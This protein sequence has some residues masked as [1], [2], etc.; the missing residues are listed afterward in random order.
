MMKK[1]FAMAAAAALTAGVTVL[2]SNPFSDVSASHWS[3]QAV[4][5]LSAQGI[6][7]GYPDG[8]FKGEKNITRYEMAQIIARLMAKEDQYNVEQR[9]SIDKLAGEYAEELDSLGVRVGN[10]EKKVGNISWSGDTRMRYQNHYAGMEEGDTLSYDLPGFETAGEELDAQK[11][12]LLKQLGY[13]ASDL[14]NTKKTKDTFD[15]RFRLNMKAQVNDDV[16][17][18]G[19]LKTTFNFQEGDSAD[20]EMDRLHVL[21]APTDKFSLDIG[22]TSLWLGQTGILYDDTFD[23]VIAKYNAGKVGIEA[24]YGREKGFND[25]FNSNIFWKDNSSKEIWYAKVTGN[26]SDKVE[27]SAFYQEF[28][29]EFN[30]DVLSALNKLGYNKSE[31]NSAALWGAGAAFHFGKFTVDGDYIQNTKSYRIDAGK[32]D[33]VLDKPVLWTAGV[34]YGGVDTNKAGSYVVGLH[35]VNAEAG[36]YFGSSTLDITDMLDYSFL[37]NG[38]KFWVARAG[39][40]LSKGV[41]LDAYYNF[42]AETQD[43]YDMDDLFGVELNYRF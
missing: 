11:G 26:V 27:L 34:N 30:S 16:T 31:D 20:V 21:Y 12:A 28:T 35:Y 39:V 15:A 3:Y 10:L 13:S 17:V 29:Q 8:T 42:A 36:S 4:S 1:I 24:G 33:T 5:D 6:V 19:R 7:D 14:A 25:S 37:T 43:G 40:A 9:A 38:A 22:R 23:G 32:N 2:A 18:L 41:E